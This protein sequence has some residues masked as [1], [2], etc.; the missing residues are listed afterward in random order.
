VAVLFDVPEE[1][2]IEINYP[3]HLQQKKK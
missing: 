3:R 2:I 1:R